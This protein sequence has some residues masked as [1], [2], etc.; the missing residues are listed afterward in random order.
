MNQYKIS[1]AAARVNAGLT[2]EDIAK[3]M[4]VSKMTVWNWENGKITPKPAQ[5][6]MF[7][8]LCNAPKDIIFLPEI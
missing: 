8:E 4:K 2:Q 6:Q 3:A 1:M 5:F 7:C